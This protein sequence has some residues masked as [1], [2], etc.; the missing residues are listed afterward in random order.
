MSFDPKR[1]ES[2]SDIN[3]MKDE[4]SMNDY[5]DMKTDKNQSAE[6]ESTVLDGSIRKTQGNIDDTFE[7]INESHDYN[8]PP[9]LA[10]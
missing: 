5:H 9:S 1:M 4:K 7:A 6:Q 10:L 8:N 3:F 2:G